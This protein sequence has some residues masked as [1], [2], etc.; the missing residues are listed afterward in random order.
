MNKK[1]KVKR[2]KGKYDGFQKT[3]PKCLEDTVLRNK[4]FLERSQW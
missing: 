4:R 1:D 2:K 3:G